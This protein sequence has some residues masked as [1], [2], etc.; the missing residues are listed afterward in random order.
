MYTGFCGGLLRRARGPRRR[1][2]GGP[3]WGLAPYRRTGFPP[4]VTGFQPAAAD[5]KPAP[6]ARPARWAGGRY[7][8]LRRGPRALGF[9]GPLRRSLRGCVH[10]SRAGLAPRG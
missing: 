10:I 6:P 8:P 3:R 7:A 4:A 5:E 2:G 9:G 1:P